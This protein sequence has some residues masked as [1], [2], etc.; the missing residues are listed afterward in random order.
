MDKALADF[1]ALRCVFKWSLFLRDAG[2]PPVIGL[3]VEAVSLAS[4]I[5][6]NMM[7]NAVQPGVERSKALKVCQRVPNFA[8]SFLR[9]VR[10]VLVAAGQAT[11]VA[12]DAFIVLREK[13]GRSGQFARFGPLHQCFDVFAHVA[14]HV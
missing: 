13:F 7:G 5:D 1:L 12:K 14:S 11:E 9:Q 10:G 8:E 2:F 3:R 4:P 6:I